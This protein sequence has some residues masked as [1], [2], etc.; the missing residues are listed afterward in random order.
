M[1]TEEPK[2]Q[3]PGHDTPDSNA[4]PQPE[5]EKNISEARDDIT[6]GDLSMSHHEYRQIIRRLD[7]AIIPYCSLLYLLR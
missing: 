7:W 5:N 6:D 4:S 2:N 3:D 1:S